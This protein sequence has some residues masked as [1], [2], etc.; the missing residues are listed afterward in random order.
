MAMNNKFK[1]PIC[2]ALCMMLLLTGCSG[3]ATSSESSGVPEA[4]TATT[5]TTVQTLHDNITDGGPTDDV[6]YNIAANQ[7]KF[8]NLVNRM[9]SNLQAHGITVVGYDG[10]VTAIASA[11]SEL[12]LGGTFTA[13][14]NKEIKDLGE[15]EVH[16]LN[17][18]TD[19]KLSYRR[20][21]LVETLSLNKDWYSYF[22]QAL[23][24][25]SA[26]DVDAETTAKKAAKKNG[27]AAPEVED[28]SAD[29]KPG[30]VA[31]KMTDSETTG[32]GEAAAPTASTNTTMAASAQYAKLKELLGTM[33]D[34]SAEVVTYVEQSY[35]RAYDDAYAAAYTAAEESKATEN[36]AKENATVEAV[37][38]THAESDNTAGLGGLGSLD[39]AD[40]TASNNT[41]TT[42]DEV[43]VDIAE[44]EST[45]YSKV[46]EDLSK[47]ATEAKT[48]ADKLKKG[49]TQF[50]QRTTAF[51][52]PSLN[53]T[54]EKELKKTQARQDD[55]NNAVFDFLLYQARTDTVNADRWLETLN[56]YLKKIVSVPKYSVSKGVL[57]KDIYSA[58][59]SKWQQKLVQAYETLPTVWTSPSALVYYNTLGYTNTQYVESRGMSTLID[60]PYEDLNEVVHGIELQINKDIADGEVKLIEEVGGAN[61]A[62]EMMDK[63]PKS[64][65]ADMVRM[66]F[67]I[68]SLV[69]DVNTAYPLVDAYIT[70]DA[71]V[72]DFK[73]G[74]AQTADSWGVPGNRAL[75][76]VFYAGTGAVTTLVQYDMAYEVT[77]TDSN[78]VEQKATVTDS[79]EY[80]KYSSVVSV[81]PFM[82]Y[83]LMFQGSAEDMTD[84]MTAT[85]VT[86]NQSEDVVA[87]T[88]LLNSL[89]KQVDPEKS[90]DLYARM[91]MQDYPDFKLQEFIDAEAKDADTAVLA[92]SGAR[93]KYNSSK[94]KGKTHKVLVEGAKLTD[95]EKA[96]LE[97]AGEDLTQYEPRYITINDRTSF[98]EIAVKLFDSYYGIENGL[99]T[100]HLEDFGIEVPTDEEE[101]DA[102]GGLQLGGETENTTSVAEGTIAESAA[103]TSA[104]DTPVETPDEEDEQEEFRLSDATQLS[105]L[106]IDADGNTPFYNY[107]KGA[108]KVVVDEL[109]STGVVWAQLCEYIN[110]DELSYADVAKQ[111]AHYVDIDQ[112]EYGLIFNSGTKAS[113]TQLSM[114]DDYSWSMSFMLNGEVTMDYL[115]SLLL[116]YVIVVG[117][118]TGESYAR[119]LDIAISALVNSTNEKNYTLGVD[120]YGDV[121]LF[122]VLCG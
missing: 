48:K 10:A 27:T 94:T 59:Y 34:Y 105:G 103:D 4:T 98:A 82:D 63:T 120:Y 118:M 70:T 18:L 77:Y 46:Y 57:H 44:V 76:T 31:S 3:G 71:T 13:Y 40:T 15:G 116:D 43:A 60:Y 92:I 111:S 112:N 109:D 22:S 33:G 102:T 42:S 38:S 6:Q 36:E 117:Q 72:A 21:A 29:V 58:E 55:W 35:Q 19:Y 83:T 7:E 16:W 62:N 95:A 100:R 86:S 115:R 88:R 96:E 106:Q 79:S 67:D 49:T 9:A 24:G 122:S 91:E 74:F 54:V 28:K 26:A 23:V 68:S 121:A 99:P 113:L 104:A 64:T 8:E 17:A 89:W 66:N 41:S 37:E 108:F 101:I 93:V 25:K 110:F 114:T 78:G 61:I 39:D 56:V 2:L 107:F 45:A 85:I 87:L 90:A 47:I 75:D 53:K 73:R 32:T 12:A 11:E 14:Q 81:K 5:Q 84:N 52:L 20:A 50:T 69:T 30:T 51:K 119:S 65:L 1:K 97:A 80:S